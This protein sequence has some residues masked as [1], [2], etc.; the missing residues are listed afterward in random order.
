MLLRNDFAQAPQRRRGKPAGLTATLDGLAHLDSNRPSRHEPQRRRTAPTTTNQSLRQIKCR[1]TAD[2]QRG[3]EAAFRA[4]QGALRIQTP[5]MNNAAK[6]RLIAGKRLQHPAVGPGI[7]GRYDKL[8]I[9]KLL[10]STSRENQRAAL[11]AS[12]QQGCQLTANSAAIG[13]Y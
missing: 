10:L 6:R 4:A 8:I 5:Q 11:A 1:T 12:T 7:A 13:E 3:I 2:L 9:R